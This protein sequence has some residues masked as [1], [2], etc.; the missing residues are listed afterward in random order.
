[1]SNVPSPPSP[2]SDHTFS[3]PHLFSCA[4]VSQAC[5]GQGVC[6]KLCPSTFKADLC[7]VC[8]GNNDCV[9][10]DGIPNSGAK[11]DACGECT[12]TPCNA[13]YW[14]TAI[15]QIAHQNGVGQHSATVHV[16]WGLHFHE[17][18]NRYDYDWRLNMSAPANQQRVWA[19]CKDIKA[20]RPGDVLC[21]MQ[22]F[23]EYEQVGLCIVWV[24]SGPSKEGFKEAPIPTAN[25]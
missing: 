2:A 11:V 12:R 4:M 9:G 17:S 5:D 20:M 18:L 10:C 21:V 8:G 7:G 24:L 13:S 15:N 14:Y 1:M 23:A 16:V 6:V 3:V 22:D 19:T 25:D